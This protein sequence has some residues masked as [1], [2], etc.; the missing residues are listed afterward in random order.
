[1]AVWL[2]I[3]RFGHVRESLHHLGVGSLEDLALGVK[4]EV[5]GQL[6]FRSTFEARRFRRVLRDLRTSMSALRSSTEQ[7]GDNAVFKAAKEA[8]PPDKGKLDLDFKTE[9]IE[10]NNNARS[11][12]RGGE[13][14]H[15]QL[16]KEKTNKAISLIGILRKQ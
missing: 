9:V 7:G 11:D 6:A 10:A 12:H 16:L 4:D 13:A 8:I 14:A 3:Y 2:A 1:M 5:A 15:R